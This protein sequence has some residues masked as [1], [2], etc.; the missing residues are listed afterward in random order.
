MLTSTYLENEEIVIS[1]NAF[2]SSE[3]TLP[4]LLKVIEDLK[5]LYNEKQNLI[6]ELAKAHH[7]ALIQL[8]LAAEWRDEDTGIHIIR[9]GL[10]A[11]KLSSLL[12]EP[13]DFCYRIKLAAPMHDIGKIGIPDSI[14]KKQGSLDP[15][16]RAQMNLHPEIGHKILSASNIPLFELA[17]RI[18]LSHHEKFD[19]T[20]YP[21]ALKGKKIPF[22]GRV[23]ALVDYFDALTMD[24]C[25]RK[26]LDDE[27]VRGMIQEQR[28]K[29]FDPDI[30]DV[31]LNHYDTFTKL[32][33]AINA[34]PIMYEDLISY[35]A[36]DFLN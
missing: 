13:A 7:L 10:I 16:E 1:K 30:V 2:D 28:G 3:A 31:F 34:K 17:G 25:Y 15:D 18:S 26:A 14:L 24:R 35:S 19:G 12:G 33:N 36:E 22:P 9:I 5:V 8:A 32:R 29:H 21:F 11:E 4:Q 27:T 20:G 6:K 23:V